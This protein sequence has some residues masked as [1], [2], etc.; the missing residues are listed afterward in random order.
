MRILMVTERMAPGGAETHIADVCRHLAALGDEVAVASAG[1]DLVPRLAADGIRHETLPL[2]RK[3]PLA[4]VRSLRGLAR[5]IREGRFDLVHAHARVP[6]MYL[7]FLSRRLDFRF[8]TTCHGTYRMTPARR[9]LAAWGDATLAVSDDV[10][11]YLRKEYG[12]PE[13]RIFPSQN[14]IDTD[15]FTPAGSGKTAGSGHRIVAVSRLTGETSAAAD[16][17]C[18]V[19]PEV[20]CSFPDAALTLVG[21]GE[22]E[23]ALRKAAERIN[24]AAGRIAVTVTGA[25][26]DVLPYLHNADVFVGVS[27]A[28]MEAMSC[29]LPVILAGNAGCSGILTADQCGTATRTNFCCR[30]EK[31]IRDENLLHDLLTLLGDESLRRSCGA[32]GR[33]YIQEHASA[34]H[35]ADSYR[36]LYGHLPR[37]ISF[38][39]ADI[40][41]SGYYGYG[42]AGDEA[43]L[44]A[45]LAEAHRTSPDAKI[46]VLAAHPREEE[47]RLGVR[48]I[49]RYDLFRILPALRHAR[50]LI[51]GGGTLLQDATSRRSLFY[52]T[53]LLR[54]ARLAG[55]ETALYA[56]GI[57][58]LRSPSAR[59]AVRR[60]ATAASRISLRD[61]RS[62]ELLLSLGVPEN[63]CTVTADPLL[64]APPA[65]DETYAGCVAVA[66]RKLPGM[67]DRTLR[68]AA[69]AARLLAAARGARLVVLNMHP[70]E[71]SAVS[72]TLAGALGGAEI[73]SGDAALSAAAAADVVIGMRLHALAAAALNGKVAV[74]VSP[75]GKIAA[76]LEPLGFPALPPDAAAEEIAGAAEKMLA[77]R[78]EWLPGLQKQLAALRE[79][80]VRDVSE[81]L[82]V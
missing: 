39:R 44:R 71:D 45:F 6:A 9:L 54:L 61:S 15:R 4:A 27:R 16:A 40:L 11:A 32:D 68:A 24:R 29:A 19:F 22:R 67:G 51:S 57:G 25:Q 47:K 2:D 49:G 14:G 26:S 43:M 23:K 7:G 78:E 81:T 46:A 74:G 70:A 28:A 55:A 65:P 73:V 18:R 31:P 60:E 63:R 1:G 5:L 79:D 75:D 37:R 33:R 21:G 3:T 35:M 41:L 58:P 17:L 66:A 69:A 77:A 50:L 82:R 34:R 80:A 30:G 12:V 72:R 20:L 13:S 8:V 76:F 56:S 38:P 48:C 64:L 53:S 52:Y 36:A 59:R 42:N 62:K 10:S